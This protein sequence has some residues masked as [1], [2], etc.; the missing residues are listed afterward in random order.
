LLSNSTSARYVKGLVLI[1]AYLLLSASFF[2]HKDPDLAGRSA[3]TA[4]TNMGGVTAG[5][6]K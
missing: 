2:F 4:T 3:N 6:R 1:L 5:G